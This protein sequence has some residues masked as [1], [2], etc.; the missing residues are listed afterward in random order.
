MAPPHLKIVKVRNGL[1]P[2]LLQINTLNAFKH[3][4]GFQLLDCAVDLKKNKVYVT[5]IGKLE[6]DYVCIERSR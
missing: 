4:W 6:Y 3:Q 5:S 2:V 1:G